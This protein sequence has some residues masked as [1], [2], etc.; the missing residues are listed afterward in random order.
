MT[1]GAARDGDRN[2]IRIVSRLRVEALGVDAAAEVRRVADDVTID[3]RHATVGRDSTTADSEGELRVNGVVLDARPGERDI[4]SR[5]DSR[6]GVRDVGGVSVE[7]DALRRTVPAYRAVGEGH[8][9]VDE[10]T[11]AVGVV[12]DRAVGDDERDG[13]REAGLEQVNSDPAADVVANA[14][15]FDDGPPFDHNDLVQ[16]RTIPGVGCVDA[17]ALLAGGVA[18]DRAVSNLDAALGVDAAASD[19]GDIALDT[20]VDEFHRPECVDRPAY[21][22]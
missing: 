4:A 11:G 3:E 5:D 8:V 21:P 7:T 2:L 18:F 20:R 16:V 9:A 14:R 22:R 19:V 6:S 10:H 13:C 15:A 17:A 12:F 1:D